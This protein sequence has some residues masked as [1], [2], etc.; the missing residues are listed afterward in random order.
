MSKPVLRVFLVEL[1][2]TFAIVLFGAGVVCVNQ[3]T[4]PGNLEAGKTP[5]YDQQP[6]RLGTPHLNHL[7]CR[8]ST[9]WNGLF[10]GTV[11]EF[12]LTFFLVFAIFGSVRSKA[13]WLRLGE[14]G[15]T[16]TDEPEDAYRSIDTRLAALIT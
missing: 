12:I 11:I 8:D 3:L 16:A 5:L 13:Q 6:G 10:S 14:N 4:V 7:V 1:L 9:N 2:G 15:A